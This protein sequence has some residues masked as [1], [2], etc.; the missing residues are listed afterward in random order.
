MTISKEIEDLEETIKM[1]KTK[2]YNEFILLGASFGAGIISLLLH[3]KY[4]E[5]KGLIFW[6]GA[7]EYNYIK[8]GAYFSEENKEIEE[9]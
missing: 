3:E 2:G 4:P 7:L 5:I 1:L 6:Y 8:F 9:K